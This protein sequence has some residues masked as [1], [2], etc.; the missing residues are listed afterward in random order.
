MPLRGRRQT[1]A[2][3]LRRLALNA[4]APR[5]SGTTSKRSADT[6]QSRAANT[7]T[8]SQAGPSATIVAL[9][10]T[11]PATRPPAATAGTRSRSGC[12]VRPSRS[13]HSR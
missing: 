3:S 13:G 12:Y 7:F 6:A 1:D 8:T 11:N 4:V 10:T 5:T 9:N 2:Q